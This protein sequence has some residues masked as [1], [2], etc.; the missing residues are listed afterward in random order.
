MF[1][2]QQY[3]ALLATAT[4]LSSAFQHAH[5]L[6][7]RGDVEY[8]ECIQSCLRNSGCFSGSDCVCKKAAESGFMS[9]VVTC[10]NQWC[11]ASINASDL[12]DPMQST[13][14]FSDS[15][16]EEALNAD[17]DN[18]LHGSGSSSDSSSTT[19]ASQTTQAKDEDEDEVVKETYAV[20]APASAEQIETTASPA[21]PTAAATKT[22][23]TMTIVTASSSA[24]ALATGSSTKLLTVSASSAGS[25]VVATATPS[26]GAGATT[27]GAS[28]SDSNDGTSVS[29]SSDQGSSDAAPEEGVAAKGQASMLG[30]VLAVAAA[31]AF[32]F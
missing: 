6:S 15:V 3:P 22:E 14:H 2:R 17:A 11:E 9:D 29:S 4:L 10:M 31:L 25:L 16:V 24:A 23:G 20:G 12:I 13:C 32:G 30:A 19:K 7:S 5:A 28:G 8:P 27:G 21:S 18:S 26:A 1:S